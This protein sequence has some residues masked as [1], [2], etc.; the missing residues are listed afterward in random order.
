[1]AWLKPAT[2]SRADNIAGGVIALVGFPLATLRIVQA[3]WAE[4]ATVTIIMWV[5]TVGFTRGRETVIWTI[6]AWSGTAIL[7]WMAQIGV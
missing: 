6:A 1:M 3:A 2:G 7:G 5:L 4:I